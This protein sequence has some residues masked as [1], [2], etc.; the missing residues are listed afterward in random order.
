M[1]VLILFCVSFLSYAGHFTNHVKES[2]AINKERRP[3]YHTLTNGKSDEAYRRL[4]SV[5]RLILPSAAIYDFRASY[6]QKRGVPVLENEFRPMNP[7]PTFDPSQRKIPAEVIK[8]IP[9]KDYRSELQA[10][11]KNRDR[12]KLLS[13]SL[14]IINEMKTQPEYW[15][16]TRHLVESV[17]RFA[18]F[19]PERERAAKEKGI[20]SP[21]KLLWEVMDYHLLGFSRFVRIDRLS[22]PVQKEGI[23]LLCSE[24]PDLLSD[25]H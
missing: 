23:P 24:L 14:E 17:Y 1:N 11:V 21:A 13:R 5:E 2:I 25:L 9:W 15:C 19:L 20:R 7:S 16:L 18:W 8:D 12:E 10:L 3:F 6:F 4:I 22:A